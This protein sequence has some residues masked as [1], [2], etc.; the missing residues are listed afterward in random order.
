MGHT[1]HSLPGK[2]IKLD[3]IKHL[4]LLIQVDDTEFN[5]TY[6]IKKMEL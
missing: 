2:N 3:D 1:L 6:V 4:E 5:N